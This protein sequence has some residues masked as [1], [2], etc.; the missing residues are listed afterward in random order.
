MTFKYNDG[1]RSDAGYKG[2]ARDCVVRA[3]S[4]ATDMPYQIVYSDLFEMQKELISKSKRFARS[5][6]DASP[7]NGVWKEVYRPYLKSLGWVWVPTMKIGTG[8]TTHLNSDE[9]PSGR[10]VVRVSKHLTA[11]VDGVVNDTWDCSRMGKRCV[12][13]YFY[14]GEEESR[15]G[16]TY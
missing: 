15:Y 3:I 10:L 2:N 16:F 5:S 12:Y 6:K 8:C 14:N 13:G 7:R 4:I 1:G 11:M 9:L